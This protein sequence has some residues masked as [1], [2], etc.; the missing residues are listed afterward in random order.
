MTERAPQFDRSGLHPGAAQSI[1]EAGA[2]LLPL[3]SSKPIEI[4]KPLG[5]QS[6]IEPVAD[7]TDKDIIGEPMSSWTDWSGR[8][9]GR[10]F[11][12]E[13]QEISLV[14]EGYTALRRL[15][16]KVLGAKPFNSGLSS[17]FLEEEIF[18]WWRASFRKETEQPLAA[19]LL[20]AAEQAISDHEIM[21][22]LSSIEIE[23]AFYLGSALVTPIDREMLRKY[24]NKGIE[25]NPEHADVIRQHGE[26]MLREL[27][28][29]TGVVI[30][31]TG[32][33]IYA[34]EKALAAAFDMASVLRFMCPAAVSWNVAFPCYPKGCEYIRS[35]TEIGIREG[36]MITL[37]TGLI[38][39][40]MFNWRLT[41]A[42]LDRYMKEG[43]QN[44]AAFFGD[45]PLTEFEKR[46][47]TA[48]DAYSQ[49][50]AS[51][52]VS[53]RLIYAMSA[54]EHMFL[55]DEQEPIQSGVGDR[56]AFLIAREPAKR[57]GVVANFKKAYGLRSRRVHHLT[58]IDDEEVLSTFFLN[59][60][61]A[62]HSSMRA[63]PR[64][65]D[66]KAFLDAID[67]IKFGQA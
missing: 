18:R 33:R 43:Y 40:S 32:D 17:Q 14:E 30:K 15:V 7:I 60:F 5:F 2:Q 58:S 45:R 28:H 42:E 44:F 37:S 61:L 65:R 38:D 39:L 16:E 13:G 57:M 12:Q 25:K 26:K 22:P 64:Y 46:V 54:L 9:Q 27:G 6:R 23:Q 11:V 48:V 67:A 19:H 29:L 34:K 51:H 10:Y 56:V 41:F 47:R 35:S 3:A 63:M 8:T 66:R 1:N 49:G 50:V 21:V 55:R 52:D 53:N 59:A 4:K 31:V 24:T 62:I 36:E 20:D